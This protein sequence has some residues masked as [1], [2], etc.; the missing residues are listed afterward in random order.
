LGASGICAAY[1]VIARNA[2]PSIL[3]TRWEEQFSVM[4]LRSS[5]NSLCTMSPTTELPSMR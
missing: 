1:D 3:A 4:S 2:C 5:G